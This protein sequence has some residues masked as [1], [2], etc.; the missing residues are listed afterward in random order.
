MFFNNNNDPMIY[1]TEV[2]GTGNYYIDNIPTGEYYFFIQ[3]KE[4]YEAPNIAAL[5]SEMVESD[6]R[7]KVT[8][9]GISNLKLAASL[10]S[11]AI[12]KI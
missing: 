4:T 3:S 11:F 12:E 2:D 10:Y 5:T 6:L 8:D 1:C 9:D 7:N